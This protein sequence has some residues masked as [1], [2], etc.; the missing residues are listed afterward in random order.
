[1]NNQSIPN[2][3]Y[4]GIS[5]LQLP[6]PKYLYPPEHQASSRLTYYSTFFNS[7]EINSSF[8]KV[9][10]KTTVGKWASSV[11]DNFRFTFKLWKQITHNKNLVFDEIDIHHFIQ[12]IAY[13]GH[14]KG[15]LLIQF[16]PS[17]K[18]E[19]INNLDKL[20]NVI[21]TADPEN[22]WSVAVEFRNRGWYNPD[23][24]A[25]LDTYNASLVIHDIPASA[26]PLTDPTSDFV[27]VRFHGPTGKYRG[28]YE[29]DFLLEYAEYV[30]QWL[31][32][33]KKVFVYFNNTM[34]D[35]FNN[36][37]SLNKYL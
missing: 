29:N 33:G 26:T 17:L 2:S 13:A 15:C 19:N 27:Y 14:K 37:S 1:M 22:V 11:N 10:M 28:S 30:K 6:V 32:D 34:G 35:A 21:K 18:N 24:Y 16:P 20:L 36:L 23:V 8:Y 4:A 3:Y 9:P 12:T 5:G 31:E 7:I 25:L